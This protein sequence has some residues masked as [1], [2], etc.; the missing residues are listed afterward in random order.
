MSIYIFTKPFRDQAHRAA[1]REE[2]LWNH[3]LISPCIM[4]EPFT[5]TTA[6]MARREMTHDT[7]NNNK[8]WKKKKGF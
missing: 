8:K 2:L 7:C 1:L 5:I 6:S 4:K 3:K